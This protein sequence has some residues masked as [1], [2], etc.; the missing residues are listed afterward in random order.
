MGAFRIGA[1]YKDYDKI[2]SEISK[3][4]INTLND[5]IVD[6]RDINAWK[7]V[8]NTHKSGKAW[9]IVFK[10]GDGIGDVISKELIHE[11]AF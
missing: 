8:D 6:K 4:E 2:L 3:D 10:N 9:D 11:N 7:L 1:D 5:I